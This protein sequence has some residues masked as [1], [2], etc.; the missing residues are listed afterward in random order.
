LKKTWTHFKSHFA[1]T[2]RQYMQMQGES[3]A[4]AGY[5]S[6]DSAVALNENQM[7]EATIGALYNLE[8]AT[9]ADRSVVVALT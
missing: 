1:A 6:S 4:T 8:T 3:A 9:A 5:H 7:D 2:H